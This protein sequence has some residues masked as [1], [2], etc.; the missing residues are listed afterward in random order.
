MVM[1]LPVAY[2]PDAQER[3]AAAL[4]RQIHVNTI[5]LAQRCSQQVDAI[6][7]QFGITHFQY[8]ALFSLCVGVQESEGKSMGAL[9]ED[10]LSRGSDTTRLIDRM[11]KVGLVERYPNP[12]D[13]RGVL[14][15]ASAEGRKIFTDVAPRIQDLHRSQ[16]HGLT[17]EEAETLDRLLKKTLWSEPPTSTQ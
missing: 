11:V 12:S 9:A 10:L 7:Q 5:M 2:E 3:Q 17:A 14:V 16:W 1:P 15:R 8:V 13:R 4:G 6:C